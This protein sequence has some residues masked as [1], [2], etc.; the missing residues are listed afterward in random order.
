MLNH[1]EIPVQVSFIAIT[2]NYLWRHMT[3]I[4]LKWIENTKLY[5][6]LIP[7]RYIH[8]AKVSD[9]ITAHLQ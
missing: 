5:S 6:F 1:L 4:S 3:N 7:I 9:F 8:V 2:E